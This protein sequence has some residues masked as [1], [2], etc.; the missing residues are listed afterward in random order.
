MNPTLETRRIDSPVALAAEWAPAYEFLVSFG[1]F[2]FASLHPILE[3]GQ[4]WVRQVR[5]SLPASYVEQITQKAFITALKEVDHDLLMV[6]VRA[7]PD[8]SRQDPPRFLDWLATLS[9]GNA[10][11]ALAPRLPESGPQL[12]RDFGVWRDRIVEVLRVWD[13]SY[14][15]Q[16]DPAILSGLR[17][18][19]RMLAKRLGSAP[20]LDVIE[21]V[22]N[23]LCIEPTPAVQTVTLVP[24]YHERPFNHDFLE[25]GNL[26]ILYPADVLPPDPQLPPPRLLRLTRALGDESRLRILRFLS[27]GSRSL[28]EVARFARLSQPT[29]HHHLAQL[30]AAGLVQVQFA[31]GLTTPNRY[32]LRPHALEQL[33]QQLGTYLVEHNTDDDNT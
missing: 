7:C 28:T 15:H 22:T 12:P 25:Q 16:L 26:V 21:Q 10:Y 9:P 33:A 4:S 18:E 20:A 29:V 31:P 11:E 14:F 17:E 23:G 8:A 27:G 32:G 30:R 24:Q 3:V 6:V 19:S 1:C 13:D 5:R 2:A